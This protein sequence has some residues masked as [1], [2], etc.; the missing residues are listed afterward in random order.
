MWHG[1]CV[2]PL[3]YGSVCSED[4][5]CI[6]S[7]LVCSNNVC[8]CGDTETWD[9]NK[10][11][12]DTTGDQRPGPAHDTAVVSDDMASDQL[13]VTDVGVAMGQVFGPLGFIIVILVFIGVFIVLHNQK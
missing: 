6:M 8:Q 1:Q 12:E 3:R 10:C 9:G 4:I 11:Q 13:S 5:E 7:A 2:V